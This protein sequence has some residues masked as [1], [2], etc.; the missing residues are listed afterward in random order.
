MAMV[1]QQRVVVPEEAW[2]RAVRRLGRFT[3]SELAAELRCSQSAAR[4]HLT[5]LMMLD[6]PLVSQD[7]RFGRKPIYAYIKPEDAGERFIKQQELRALAT[8][9]QEAVA[10]DLSSARGG[11]VRQS[12]LASIA[13]KELREVARE[14]VE[15]GWTYV[16]PNGSSKA[17]LTNGTRLVMIPNSPRNK[18]DAAEMMRQQ[19]FGFS[20]RHHKREERTAS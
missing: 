19:L 11:E 3:L 5:A 18:E 12:R 10:T 4:E 8:P 2:R 1:Q 17:R 20:A 15:R 7:G 16:P 6:P 14:A 13:V 9:E